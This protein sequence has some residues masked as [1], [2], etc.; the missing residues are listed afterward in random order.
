MG[1]I[2]IP[3]ISLNA[4]T[5][6]HVEHKS[7]CSSG[8]VFTKQGALSRRAASLT[9]HQKHGDTPFKQWQQMHVLIQQCVKV[10]REK[11]LTSQ[12]MEGGQIA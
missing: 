8:N 10:K 3:Q 12:E 2:I 7:T 4:W 5:E 9:L 11:R 6:V 1:L